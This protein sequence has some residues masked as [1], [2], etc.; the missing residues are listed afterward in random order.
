MGYY[1]VVVSNLYGQTFSVNVTLSPQLHFLPP[2]LFAGDSLP[3]FLAN[4]D[5]SLVASNRAARVQI[6][7][8]TNWRFR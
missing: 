1:S 4:S 7:A 5:G 6:Y 2:V 8:S 3:L